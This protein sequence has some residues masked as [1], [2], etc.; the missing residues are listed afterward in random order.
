MGKLDGK[1]SIITGGA[2]GIGEATVRLFAQEGAKIVI[3]D[4]LDDY[5]SKLADELG[6]N[7]EFV[8]T[9]VNE[10]KDIR[11]L[12]R[13]AKKS[14]G[15][16]DII[17]NNAGADKIY[18]EFENISV[19]DFDWTIGVH[20]RATFLGMKYAVRAMKKQRS[21]SIINVGSVAGFQAGYASHLYSAAKAGI[22]HMTKTVSWELAPFGIRVNCVCPG[23]I[24]TA[25]FG[26]AAGM[27]Q[28]QAL[29]IIPDIKKVFKT[30]QPIRR[31][32]LP[33]DIARAV[34]WLAS[35]DSSF[36]TGQALLI[37][38]GI[39]NGPNYEAYERAMTELAQ[40]L[41]LEFT[42]FFQ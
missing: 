32:G 42:M 13:Y 16:L 21:G 15:Q 9:D 26:K 25:I 19:N 33:E 7:V 10:E 40:I 20:L 1:I 28:A 30:I 35:N 18:T 6:Q 27:S 2:S 12:V 4:I 17:F 38:G 39:L 8:H 3:G 36:V 41:G 37:D 5:G 34:L 24:S 14:L 11:A 31:A 22:I 23:A 29:K